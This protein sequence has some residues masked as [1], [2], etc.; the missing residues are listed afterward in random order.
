M[1]DC[2]TYSCNYHNCLDLLERKRYKNVFAHRPAS[3]CGGRKCT[4]SNFSHLLVTFVFMPLYFIDIRYC[5]LK[6][7][8]QSCRREENVTM[9]FR[10][11]YASG[12]KHY[13]CI[14]SNVLIHYTRV[15][16]FSQ[17]TKLPKTNIH[18]T[19]FFPVLLCALWRRRPMTKL[20]GRGIMHN[21]K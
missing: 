17:L 5:F 11:L 1:I 7:N 21:T 16:L 15:P 6:K 10:S 13:I 2:E 8:E 20:S 19:I 4:S 3:R 14:Y 18:P 12:N 9:Y